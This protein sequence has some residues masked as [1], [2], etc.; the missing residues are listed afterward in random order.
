MEN[1][2]C[3]KLD[4]PRIFFHL[5]ELQGNLIV[6]VKKAAYISRNTTFVRNRK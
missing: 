6:A 2:I 4:N 5:L 1:W 3:A